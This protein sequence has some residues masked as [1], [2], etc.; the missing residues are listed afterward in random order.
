MPPLRSLQ[1]TPPNPYPSPRINF[2]ILPIHLSHASANITAAIVLRTE[3][4]IGLQKT[5]LTQNIDF[6]ATV[7]ATLTLAE[8]TF[9]TVFSDGTD[10]QC[11]QSLLVDVDSN[12]GAQA[13]IGGEIR[14]HEFEHGR[15]VSTVYLSAGTTTCLDSQTGAADT[16]VAPTTSASQVV[17][18]C[19]TALLTQT[20]SVTKVYTLTSCAVAAI[21]CPASLAQVIVATT[22]LPTVTTLCPPGFNSTNIT[23]TALTPTVAPVSFYA[24]G[25]ITLPPLKTPVAASIAPIMLANATVPANATIAGVA[26]TVPVLTTPPPEATAEINVGGRNGTASMTSGVRGGDSVRAGLIGLVGVMVGA[27][28]LL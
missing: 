13:K 23:A 27:V 10:G 7:S 1:R 22:V 21:N 9:G 14:G 8:L 20:T 19:P 2:S 18:A 5:P 28:V 16:S 24:A 4:G 15:D 26:V 12:A 6:A 11:K 17:P 3:A 25:V